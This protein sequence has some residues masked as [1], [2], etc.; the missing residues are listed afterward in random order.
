MICLVIMIC[1]NLLSNA[2]LSSYLDC[3]H[4]V[5]IEVAINGT[6]EV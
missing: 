2:A 4:I 1:T 6:V 3:H 5:G